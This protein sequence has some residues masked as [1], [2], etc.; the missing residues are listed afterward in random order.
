MPLSKT[1]SARR[2]S[3]RAVLF[4]GCIA[5]LSAGCAMQPHVDVLVS[6]VAPAQS[7]MLEQRAQIDVHIRNFSD[8]AIAASGM[9]LELDVNGRSFARGVS[10]QTFTV[11]ALGEATTTVVV[12]VSVFDV[13][14]QLLALEYR[15]TYDYVLRGKIF[16]SGAMTPDTRFSRR[17][18]F[19]RAQLATL[20]GQQVR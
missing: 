11:P 7:T 17:G 14:R 1:P 2:S 15:A 13:V 5:L 3:W 16:G 18:E 6:R 10:N 8:R 20:G 4:A 12:G 19:T 9:T